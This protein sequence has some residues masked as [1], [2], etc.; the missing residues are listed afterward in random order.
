MGDPKRTKKKYDTPR[1]PWVKEV[2]DSEKELMREYGLKNK[3]EVWKVKSE[4]RNLKAQSKEQS[5]ELSEGSEDKG[6][7]LLQKL[8]KIGVLNE[9]QG[10]DD[11]LGLD[12][13]DLMERRLQTVLYRKNLA[14]SIKQARQ[15][16]VHNHVLVKDKVINVPGYMVKTDEEAS[17]SFSIGSALSSA[18]HPEISILQN[19]VQR[20]EE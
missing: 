7:A 15:F 3:K 12:I 11:V 8:R 16:I 20:V 14:N 18:E 9:S 6:E 17:I 5:K 10:L 19:K 2:I 4:L 13:K 1:H